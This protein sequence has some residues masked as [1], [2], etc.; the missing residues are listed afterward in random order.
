MYDHVF[1]GSMQLPKACHA[2][3]QPRPGQ[4]G[5]E[6]CLIPSRAHG[7]HAMD[8]GGE[9]RIRLDELR[10]DLWKGADGNAEDEPV[11]TPLSRRTLA[12]RLDDQFL[13][14]SPAIIGMLEIE[15]AR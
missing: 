3:G 15:T 7:E 6:P 2:T 11:E 1:M 8:H 10:A 9:A 4:S 14:A 12:G 5:L 13:T